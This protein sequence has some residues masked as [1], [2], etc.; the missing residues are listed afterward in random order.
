MKPGRKLKAVIPGGSSAPVLTADEAIKATMDYECLA[1][2][3]SMLGSGAVIVL[4]DSN[5]MVDMLSVLM[6]FY[7]MNPVASA[8][9]A[10]KAR[11]G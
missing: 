7:I 3:G 5:C 11:V 9:P 8:H 10:A 1:Q 2:M 4:D 6:H